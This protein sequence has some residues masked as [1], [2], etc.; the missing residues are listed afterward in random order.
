VSDRI[1]AF[2]DDP[3]WS[4]QIKDLALKQNQEANFFDNN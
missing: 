2:L 4:E 3:H 1:K